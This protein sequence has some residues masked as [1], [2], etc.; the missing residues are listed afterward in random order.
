VGAAE[1]QAGSGQGT[2]E[3]ICA[4][5]R[6]HT[7]AEAQPQ[8]AQAGAREGGHGRGARCRCRRPRCSS[9]RRPIGRRRCG[10]GCCGGNGLRR[11]CP[12]EGR[13]QVKL[14]QGAGEGGGRAR[15][16]A[17]R[18][19]AR[20]G[21]ILRRRRGGGGEGAALC[22]GADRRAGWLCST[23]GHLPQHARRRAFFGWIRTVL[24]CHFVV[25]SQPRPAVRTCR[26]GCES[27]SSISGCTSG[28]T[29]APAGPYKAAASAATAAPA[30]HDKGQARVG[31]QEKRL[32]A[33]LA[34][35]KGPAGTGQ[36]KPQ[37][38][39]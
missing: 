12:R 7:C 3:H 16:H 14:Q 28:P 26:Y 21:G 39:R 30:L 31:G 25:V 17:T 37:S 1:G 36:S 32:Q 5:P 9:T 33:L 13:L 11:R 34:A 6:S 22:N 2:W 27:S 10:Q 15:Q 8:R 19:A 38:L 29:A 4:V 35:A 20:A 18:A 23:T 24:Q